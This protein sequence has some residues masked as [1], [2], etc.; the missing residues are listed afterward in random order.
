V[1]GVNGARLLLVEHI[2]NTF[3]ILDLFP[4]VLLE[5]VIILRN[6]YSRNL[7]IIG[8]SIGHLHTLFNFIVTTLVIVLVDAIFVLLHL[9]DLCVIVL[10]YVLVISVVHYSL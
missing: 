5:N 6:L 9:L 7:E 2:E 3:E 10:I 4:G 8:L 1:L